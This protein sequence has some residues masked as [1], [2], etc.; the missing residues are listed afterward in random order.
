MFCINCGKQFQGEGY[1]C[2]ECAAQKAAPAAPAAAPQ[3]P[4]YTPPVYTPPVY[5]QPAAPR[6]AAPQPAQS[7]DLGTPVGGKKK[8]N[9]GLI[10]LV[11]I[12]ALALVGGGVALALN[13]DKLFTRVPEDPAEYVAFLEEPRMQ[14]LTDDLTQAYGKWLEAAD[15]GSAMDMDIKLHLGEDLLNGISQGLAAGGMGELD[16]KW[17]QDITLRLHSNTPGDMSA[18]QS[19]M[20]LLLGSTSLVSLDTVVDLK[21]FIVYVA[22]PE[23]NQTPLK[24]DYRQLMAQQGLELSLEE[25]MA[26]GT[27]LIKDLPDQKAVGKLAEGCTDIIL[28]YLTDA[29]K[30]TCELVAGDASQEVTVLTVTLTEKQLAKLIQELLEYIQKDKTA[31]QLVEAFLN[32]SNGLNELAGAG[33]IY[34]MDDFD[35]F[36]QEG[37]DTMKEAAAGASKGN[38]VLL[39]TYVD[40]DQI[41]G[42]RMQVFSNDEQDADLGYTLL[43]Q[44][45]TAYLEAYVGEEMRIAGEADIRKNLLSGEYI[46]SIEGE[47]CLALEL[48]DVNAETGLGT[49]LL[50]LEP[51]AVTAMDMDSNMGALI[52]TFAIQVDV[53]EDGCELSVLAGKT[54]MLSLGLTASMSEGSK[55][56][57]PDNAVD[58]TDQAALEQWTRDVRLDGIAD[59]LK[60]AG[61]PQELQAL[62]DALVQQWNAQLGI[63][64]Y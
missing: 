13:W 26:L 33:E 22:V 38:Y 3:E 44:E 63:S 9:V 37:I 8:K 49:Y 2:P 59:S 10:V 48:K 50:S 41:L 40:G 20:E 12:L 4:V 27:Q 21:D 54:T 31:Q 36:I 11:I 64:G 55:V 39:S 47:D 43:T 6:P 56:K 17:L 7:F 14:A 35:D 24:V 15:A 60:K 18:T 23:L 58:A 51:G 19:A 46:L 32:Y 30:D 16:M 1:L 45:N 28:R 61:L 57:V 34:T 29:E 62:V 25:T 42:R 5:T 52:T 53:L